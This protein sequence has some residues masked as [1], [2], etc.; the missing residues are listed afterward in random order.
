[1]IDADGSTDPAEIP[2]FVKALLAGADF[3]KGTRFAK[4]GGSAD[5]TRFRSLG[6]R[7]L[8][9]LVNMLYHTRYSDLCY[10]FN[11]FWR[12]H[13]PIFDLDAT[14]PAP[15]DGDGRLWGDGFEV[16]T[17]I[18]IRVAKAGL[19]I[20]EI[21]SFE[22]PRI[23]GVSNLSTASDG[24]RVLRTILVERRRAA[25]EVAPAAPARVI[26]DAPAKAVDGGAPSASASR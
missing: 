17:L 20:A 7:A 21:P 12:R 6:N 26:R 2:R 4:G 14:S 5:I 11:V 13:L 16:E 22:R 23:H 15:P 10:G 8:N 24:L 1:M 19:V 18:N 25:G 3:A 9:L